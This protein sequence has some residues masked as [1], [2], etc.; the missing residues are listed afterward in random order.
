MDTSTAYQPGSG[1]VENGRMIEL[2]G[3]RLGGGAADEVPR[4]WNRAAL[5]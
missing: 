5:P 2:V 3:G 1:K 4:R